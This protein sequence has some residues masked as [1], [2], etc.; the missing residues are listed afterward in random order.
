MLTEYEAEL[1]KLYL[2]GNKTFSIA[3]SYSVSSFILLY[4]V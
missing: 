4:P 2:V 3:L 1:K